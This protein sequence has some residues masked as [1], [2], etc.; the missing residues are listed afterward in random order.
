M[1]VIHFFLVIG[2]HL[3]KHSIHTKWLLLCRRSGPPSTRWKAHLEPRLLPHSPHAGRNFSSCIVIAI[4]I[5]TALS[6]N[7]ILIQDSKIQKIKITAIVAIING[8]FIFFS[9]F[10]C[11]C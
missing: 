4:T 11:G 3:F 8:I 2:R 1:D 10:L 6:I 5:I 7:V 9:K